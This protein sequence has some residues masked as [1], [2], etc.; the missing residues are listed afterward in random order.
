[1]E[2]IECE[3]YEEDEVN[4]STHPVWMTHN[5][6]IFI[7]D[8]LTMMIARDMEHEAVT[9]M[10][11]LMPTAKLASPVD[12]LDKMGIAVLRVTDP[13][14]VD[15]GTTVHL[16]ESEIYMLRE[17]CHSYCKVGDE[18]V[19]YNLKRKLYTVLYR[20]AYATDKT[21][22]KLLASVEMEAPEFIPKGE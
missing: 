16:N 18:Y 3:W 11:P 17:I 6:V 20:D 2:F 21:A 9:S 14:C 15:R 7:D 12:L 13:E 5:E 1:M 19:G 8:S 22:S 4:E 10:R